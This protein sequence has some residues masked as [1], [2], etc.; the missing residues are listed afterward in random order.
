MKIALI[1]GAAK[2][3]GKEIAV[4][5]SKHGWKVIIHYNSSQQEALQLAKEING[6]AVQADL[7]NDHDLG[8]LI[9]ALNDKVDLLINNASVFE[10]S[11]PEEKFS[12]QLARIFKVNLFT[13]IALTLKC[14][15]DVVN[16]LDAASQDC[17]EDFIGY[18]LSKTA[19]GE[20]TQKFASKKKGSRINALALGP[21]LIKDGQSKEVFDRIAKNYPCSIKDVCQG[22]DY[23]LSNK[24][25]NGEIIDLTKWK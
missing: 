22:I 2:R 13:P 25:V 7:T 9:D 14:R 6:F 10:K 19:L 23:I 1:T 4:H 24:T 21:C 11:A 17:S 18:H 3:I 12:E 20:F 5:L 16:I 8:R 15:G